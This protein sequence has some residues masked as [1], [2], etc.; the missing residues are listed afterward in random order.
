MNMDAEIDTDAEHQ[1]Y[2]RKKKR[3]CVSIKSDYESGEDDAVPIFAVIQF[4]LISLCKV[5]WLNINFFLFYLQL[6]FKNDVGDGLIAEAV[7]IRTYNEPIRLPT[8]V[9]VIDSAALNFDTNSVV[10]SQENVLLQCPGT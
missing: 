8:K 6:V 2:F 4:K 3:K 1:P 5:M 9:T 10:I 7:S